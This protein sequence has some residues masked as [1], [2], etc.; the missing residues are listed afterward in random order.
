MS[1]KNNSVILAS[2]F[3]LAAGAVA[4]TP[5]S[6]EV[7]LE[8]NKCASLNQDQYAD[9][10]TNLQEKLQTKELLDWVDYQVLISVL[11]IEAKKRGG[12]RVNNTTDIREIANQILTKTP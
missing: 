5:K 1:L 11:N 6:I 8:P 10:K 3:T 7:C 4:L 9:L 2:V 12:I